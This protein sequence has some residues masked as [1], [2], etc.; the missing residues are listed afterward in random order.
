MTLQ[1]APVQSERRI[2]VGEEI[3]IQLKLVNAE[4]G[5]SYGNLGPLQVLVFEPTEG[6]QGQGRANPVAEGLYETTLPAP[7]TGP[8]YLFFSCPESKIGY[9]QLPHLIIDATA[10]DMKVVSRAPQA[11]NADGEAA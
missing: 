8:C 11:E 7:S 6:W 5:R 3:H 4:T 10:A 9:A 2:L 1:I